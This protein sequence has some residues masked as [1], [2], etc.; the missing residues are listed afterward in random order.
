MNFILLQTLVAYNIIATI[1][2]FAVITVL[3]SLIALL[4]PIETKGRAMKV[5][6]TVTVYM[7]DWVILK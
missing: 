1:S 4:L 6:F 7:Y 2:L 3:A 5:T